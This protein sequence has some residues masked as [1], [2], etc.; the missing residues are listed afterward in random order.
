MNSYLV[1]LV[2]YPVVLFY[3]QLTNET[4]M[5]LTQFEKRLYAD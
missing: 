1:C 5:C 4:N 3:L 2:L